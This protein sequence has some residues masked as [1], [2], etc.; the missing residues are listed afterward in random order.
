[1]VILSWICWTTM[2]SW[3]SIFFSRPTWLKQA[4]A[5]DIITTHVLHQYSTMTRW[6]PPMPLPSLQTRN[7]YASQFHGFEDHLRPQQFVFDVMDATEQPM[8]SSPCHGYLSYFS[9]K[10]IRAVSAAALIPQQCK[11]GLPVFKKCGNTSHMT[12]P[13]AVPSFGW[14]C[15]QP[16]GFGL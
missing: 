14:D 5:L 8:A 13:M 16:D 6:R 7:R 3:V 2:A 4:A 1:M 15:S 12:F 9:S 11:F 10:G